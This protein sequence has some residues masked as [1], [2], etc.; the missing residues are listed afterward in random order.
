MSSCADK[1]WVKMAPT[2]VFSTQVDHKYKNGNGCTMYYYIDLVY[3]FTVY[4]SWAHVLASF[5]W[6]AAGMAVC[7]RMY[8]YMKNNCQINS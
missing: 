1:R 3:F 7:G 6:G 8:L 4:F 2:Q 5:E